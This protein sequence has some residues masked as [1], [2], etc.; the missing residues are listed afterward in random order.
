MDGRGLHRDDPEGGVSKLGAKSM[1]CPQSD[2][3][4]ADVASLIG[5]RNH[6]LFLTLTKHVCGILG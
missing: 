1:A 4:I 2:A 5:A 3:R 6:G